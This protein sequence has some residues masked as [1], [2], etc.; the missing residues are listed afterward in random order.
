MA[1][2]YFRLALVAAGLI[3]ARWEAGAMLSLA[4][5]VN[6]AVFQGLATSSAAAIRTTGPREPRG[7]MPELPPRET[8]VVTERDPNWVDRHRRRKRPFGEPDLGS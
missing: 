7:D 1:F 3:S 6:M 2:I 4:A 8:K 5:P